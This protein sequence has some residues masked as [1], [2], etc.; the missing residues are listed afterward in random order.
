MSTG[1]KLT[2]QQADIVDRL[3]AWADPWSRSP[4]LRAASLGRT[5]GRMKSLGEVLQTLEVATRR[6]RDEMHCYGAGAEPHR[7]DQEF[8]GYRDR[9]PETVAIGR[10]KSDPTLIAQRYPALIRARCLTKSPEGPMKIQRCSGFSS[11]RLFLLGFAFEPLGRSNSSC[12]NYGH[13]EAA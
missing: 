2:E 11:L 6:I 7:P 12:S 8:S 13:L 5:A 1:T 4:Q 10:V 3:M 9:D